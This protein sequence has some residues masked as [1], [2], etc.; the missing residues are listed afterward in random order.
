MRRREPKSWLRW[1]A[2]HRVRT[3]LFLLGVCSACAGLG[4]AFAWLGPCGSPVTPG[5]TAQI[6]FIVAMMGSAALI[7]VFGYRRDQKGTE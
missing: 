7:I 4:V 6:S 5:T 3:H 2:A 1:I